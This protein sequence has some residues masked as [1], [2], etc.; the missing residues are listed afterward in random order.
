MNEKSK[1]L[2]QGNRIALRPL[3]ASDAGAMYAS[4]E[5][6][7]SRR[8]TGTY[9][10][11]TLEEVRAHCARI[12]NAGDRW[13]YGVTVDGDLIG[14]VVLNNVDRMNKSASL[15]IAIW[16]PSERNK[17]Y[18]SEAAALL[19]QHGFD[20]LGLN[21]I[22]LAVYSFNPQARR[23]YEKLGFQVEG[24]KREALIWYGEVV[25]AHVMSLLR[26]EYFCRSV[27]RS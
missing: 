20:K 5:E 6:P 15:R 16:D 27:A 13:D 25:D 3:T 19:I 17:G 11:Y 7:T 23:V 21:R 26:S 22:E 9:A 1:P 14:E 8:L 12:E 4:L 2:L 10:E 24:T 18:G